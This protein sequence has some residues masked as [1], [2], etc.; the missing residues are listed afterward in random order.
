MAS[1]K[2]FINDPTHLVLTALHSLTLTNPSLSVDLDNKTVFRT[3]T[4]PSTVS[5]ISGGGSG[6]EP[7]FSSF[8]G[9]GLLTAAVAGTIFA[10][11]SAEQIR[12]AI[13]H[14]VGGGRRAGVLVVVMNYTGDILNFGMG[15]E[16]ARAQGM[17]VEMVVVADDAGVG[18]AKGGKVGRRGIAGTCLVLK[19]AGALAEG[20]ASLKDCARVARLVADNIVSVGSSLSHVHV[21]GRSGAVED[22]MAQDEIEIGMGIHNEPGSERAKASLPE[23][24]KKMLAQM[25][26]PRDKDRNFLNV[27]NEDKTVLLVNN[28]GGVSV[29]ELGGI[30]NEVVRQLKDTYGIEPVRILAGTYMTSLNGMGFSISLLKLQDTELGHGKSMLELLDSPAEANGWS[31]AVQTGTWEAKST[32]SAPKEISTQEEEAK[33]TNL[34]SKF[35]NLGLRNCADVSGSRLRLRAEGFRDCTEATHRRRTRHYE[36]RHNCRRR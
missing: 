28:L 34:R 36:L 12:N 20:G 27:S 33:P 6:H 13:L 14:R 35:H 21:P 26:D 29:L 5:L 3:S 31:A 7:A 24:V 23:L 32:P 16:K 19:I 8:V 22:E 17:H 11:P 2:H 18:R 4:D 10:S 1:T 30:T 25:L 15:V 9:K